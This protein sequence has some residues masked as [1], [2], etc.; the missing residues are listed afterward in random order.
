[1]KIAVAAFGRWLESEVDQHT[2]RA[3]SFVLYD[4]EE[5]SF[6]VFE[7]WRSSQCIHWAGSSAANDLVKAGADAVIVRN[8]GPCAFRVFQEARIPV[9]LVEDTTV[10]QAIRQMREGALKTADEPNCDGHI[11]KHSSSGPK[12]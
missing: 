10:V 8:I 5:E 2:G 4:T 1:M 6:Q 11:H 12:E 9:Y 7:N 3:L